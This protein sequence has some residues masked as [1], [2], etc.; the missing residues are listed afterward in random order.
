MSTEVAMYRRE[1]SL[2]RCALSASFCLALAGCASVSDYPAGWPKISEAEINCANVAGEYT[3]KGV[4][5]AGGDASLSVL[6]GLG[7]GAT[8]VAILRTQ[9][10]MRVTAYAVNFVLSDVAIPITS[11]SCESRAVTYEYKGKIAATYHYEGKPYGDSFTQ[12]IALSKAVDGSLVVHSRNED[13]WIAAVNL[14]ELP[15]FFT[16]DN[17]SRFERTKR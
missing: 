6:F 7:P 15:W 2:A 11:L 8:R 13:T 12:K 14:G 1:F 16:N 5:A 17:W 9:D 3:N 4:N 10:G